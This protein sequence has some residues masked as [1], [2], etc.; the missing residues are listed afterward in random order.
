MFFPVTTINSTA[1]T[2]ASETLLAP[3]SP[4]AAHVPAK[5]RAAV[6]EATEIHEKKKIN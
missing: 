6:P 1:Q 3:L 4:A 2:G 5:I